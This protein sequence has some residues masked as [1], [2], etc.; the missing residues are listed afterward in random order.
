MRRTL[1][2]L[3]S[4]AVLGLASSAHAAL[5]GFGSAGY[6]PRVPV[7]PL[8]LSWFDASRLN[9]SSTLSVGSGSGFGTNALQ[10]TR[11]SYSFDAPVW[12]SVS[13][14]NSFGPAAGRGSG[15]FFLEGFEAAYRPTPNMFFQV[16]Y[17]DFRSPLQMSPLG[18]SPFLQDGWGR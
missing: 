4:V 5:N 17:R 9:V 7:S 15:K 11:L 6:A 1:T 13:L 8:A 18:A 3:A 12:L 2:V 10:V 16:Q 14:G